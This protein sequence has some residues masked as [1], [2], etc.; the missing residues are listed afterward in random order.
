MGSPGNA[1]KDRVLRLTKNSESSW[2]QLMKILS[3]FLIIL[4]IVLAATAAEALDI[5]LAS[6]KTVHHP[7]PVTPLADGGYLLLAESGYF[8][9]LKEAGLHYFPVQ[10]CHPDSLLVQSGSFGLDVFTYDDLVRLAAKHPDQIML[11]EDHQKRPE[12]LGF[13]R[14][15]F[16]FSEGRRIQAY[17]RDSSRTGCPTSLSNLFRAIA[18]AGRYLSLVDHFAESDSLTRMAVLTATL[19]LPIFTLENVKTAA[20]SDRAFP[21]GLVRV[22][23]NKRILDIDFQCRC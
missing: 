7:F 19:D 4:S 1:D 20:V 14:A 18:K 16:K 13:K 3:I 11:R 23:T 5:D 10:V 6:I 2:V 12:P 9:A 15:E 17:L 22:K 21:P 8:R